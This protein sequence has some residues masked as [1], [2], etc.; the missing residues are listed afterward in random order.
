MRRSILKCFDVE[1]KAA[2]TPKQSILE[3]GSAIRVAIE[4]SDKT[5]ADD[6]CFGGSPLVGLIG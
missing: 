6:L 2:Q 5:V 1:Y 4:C 3:L